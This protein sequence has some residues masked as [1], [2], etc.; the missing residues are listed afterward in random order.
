MIILLIRQGLE[1]FDKNEIMILYNHFLEIKVFDAEIV[2][3]MVIWQK[4][5]KKKLDLLFVTCAERKD[6]YL[7]TVKMQNVYDVDFLMYII[8]ILAVCIADV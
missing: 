5:A 1:F 3:T 2:T 7:I 4:I 8:L 6:T